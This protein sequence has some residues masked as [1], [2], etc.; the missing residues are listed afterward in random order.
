MSSLEDLHIF[1]LYSTMKHGVSMPAG[2]ISAWSRLFITSA[3]NQRGPII[4]SKSVWSTMTTPGKM[5]AIIHDCKDHSLKLLRVDHPTPSPSQYLVKVHAVG[6]TKGELQWPEPHELEAMTAVPGF[7]VAGTVI[8]APLGASKCQP[9]DRIM[10]MTAA[11]RPANAREITLVEESEIALLPG[12]LTFTDAAA[13]PMSA[14]TASE[15][16]FERGGFAKEAGAPANRDKSVLVIGASGAVGIWAIQLAK[17][18]GIGTIVGICGTKN[19]EFVKSLGASEV[20]D[21]SQ[22]SLEDRMLAGGEQSKFDMVLDGVGC[23]MLAEAWTAIKSNGTLLSIVEP[24][25]GTRPETGV[26]EGVNAT[27]FIVEWRGDRLERLSRLIEE[28]YAKPV[29]DS[30][31]HLEDFQKAFD[32]VETGRARGKV[33][34]Q[35]NDS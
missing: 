35:I 4:S 3:R 2:P 15:A 7:D 8:R 23:K 33:I 18:A 31:F 29:V 24:V 6:I 25:E 19:V 28:G 12:A 32:H 17:W 11:G 5:K 1:T 14:L 26:S 20:M 16:L 21:H 13:V 27:F 34:L 30:V 9:G 10:A 22:E